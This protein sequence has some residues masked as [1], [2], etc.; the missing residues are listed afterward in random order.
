MIHH[1][2]GVARKGGGG[3]PWMH[4]TPPLQAFLS[5]NN[6]QYAGDNLVSTFCTTQCD[7]PGYAQAQSQDFLE[8]LK[9]L[10]FT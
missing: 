2:K 7:P 6:L 1:N 5:A 9:D 8:F 4:V 10:D 3:G